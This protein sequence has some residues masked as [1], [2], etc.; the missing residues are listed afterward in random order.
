MSIEVFVCCLNSTV[1]YAQ[2]EKINKNILSLFCFLPGHLEDLES[3]D[4]HFCLEYVS[5]PISQRFPLDFIISDGKL[6]RM[7]INPC[8]SLNFHTRTHI[9]LCLSS[10]LKEKLKSLPEL[11]VDGKL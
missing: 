4:F 10:D 11:C 8:S 5:M 9:S 1:L 3:R 6:T 7:T 2:G